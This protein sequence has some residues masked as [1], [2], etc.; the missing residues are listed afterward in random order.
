MIT[1]RS[2]AGEINVLLIPLVLI[3]LF[4]VGA[5]SFAYWAYSERLDYKNN[6]DKKVAV[7]V[8][9]ARKDEDI[10]KDKAFVEAEK[11]P[12]TG[13]DGPEAYGSVHV[14]YPK[15]WSV[16]I[17][18]AANGTQ[19]L[20]SF[21]NPRFV[22]SVQDQNSVFALRVQ[23]LQQQYTQVVNSFS[24]GVKQGT[25]TVTPYSLPKVPQATGV[26]AD[27]IL[28]PGKKNTGS[29]VVMPLRDKTIEIWTENA[30]SINDFNTIILPNLTFQP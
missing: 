2:Q 14:D 5:T 22:P 4:F 6:S 18:S 21:F 20:D 8:A 30:Q 19:P 28:H 25:L 12:L 16:Y 10:I 27:G 26:R 17:H 23:V 3:T 29:M 1:P 11:Q 13:Y 24:N 9:Q 15:T 7:A